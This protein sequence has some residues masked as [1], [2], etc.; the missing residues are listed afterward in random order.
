M[1]TKLVVYN[2]HTLG[3]IMPELPNDVCIIRSLQSKGAPIRFSYSP[4]PI[5]PLDNIRLASEKDFDD[6]NVYFG[7]FGNED[8][9]AK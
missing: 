6:F 8:E 2:E 7:S 5:S 9:Y 3:Y 4:F 1:K